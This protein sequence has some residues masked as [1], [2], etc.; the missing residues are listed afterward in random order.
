MTIDRFITKEEATEAQKQFIAETI[1]TGYREAK[2]G[3]FAGENLTS[4]D[5]LI[6]ELRAE[7]L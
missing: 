7:T 2:E 1:A 4:I 5:G 3:K 6:T